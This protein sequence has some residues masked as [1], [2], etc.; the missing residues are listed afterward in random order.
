MEATPHRP[1]AKILTFPLASRGPAKILS[2]R[3]KFEAEL[4]SLRGQLTDFG[5]AW[6]HDEAIQDAQRQRPV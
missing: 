2:S 3:A 6:Y 4:A 5:S 1:S